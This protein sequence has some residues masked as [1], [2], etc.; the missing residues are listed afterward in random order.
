MLIGA[1][2]DSDSFVKAQEFSLDD[3]RARWRFSDTASFLWAEDV[4]V[5]EANTG[6]CTLRCAR[7]I[8]PG[9]FIGRRTPHTLR[10]LDE[11]IACPEIL[12]ECAEFRRTPFHERAPRGPI[13]DEL[14]SQKRPSTRL[15]STPSSPQDIW[16]FR[17]VRRAMALPAISYGPSQSLGPPDWQHWQYHPPPRREPQMAHPRLGW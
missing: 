6:V 8:G 4:W 15:C 14:T 1:V 11:L 10:M 12:P 9:L 3:L 2:L 7:L 17:R 16:C 13:D 5:D